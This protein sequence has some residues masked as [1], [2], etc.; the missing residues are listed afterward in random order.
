M[1]GLMILSSTVSKSGSVLSPSAKG[2]GNA[3]GKSGQEAGQ[4]VRVFSFQESCNSEA[5]HEMRFFTGG[6]KEKNFNF[7]QE[8]P[9]G[10]NPTSWVRGFRSKILNLCC[11]VKNWSCFLQRR[12]FCYFCFSS[13][14]YISA[15]FL[16][17]FGWRFRCCCEKGLNN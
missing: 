13:I 14:M 15:C 11:I 6:R 17:T 7:S 10:S 9:I 4:G 12:L 5:L 1:G 3:R 2:L 8:S 16:C